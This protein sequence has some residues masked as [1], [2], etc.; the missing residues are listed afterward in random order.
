MSPFLQETMDCLVQSDS[1]QA[2][3]AVRSRPEVKAPHD[4]IVHVSAVALN[5]TDFKSPASN[6]TPGA[7]MGCDFMGSVVSAGTAADNE[8]PPATRVCGFVHGSNPGNPETGSFAEYLVTDSRLLIRVPDSWTNVDGAALGGVGWGTVAL[9]M[10]ISLQL[11]GR[12]S[13]P[14]APRDDGS[15]T[16][17]LVYGGA[18]ATGTMACQILSMSGYQPVATASS[19]SSTLVRD[20]GAVAVVPYSSPTCGETIRDDHTGGALR[21]ALDCI[22]SP[23]SVKCCFTALGRIGARYAGLD[24]VPDDWRTR[25]AI[26]VH[27][28]LTYAL[29]GHEIK[30]KGAYHRDADPAML[31]LGGRWRDEVQG[32][33]DAGRLRPHP[34]RE[35]KGKWKGIVDGL[36]MMKAGEVRGQKL[37]VALEGGASS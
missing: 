22:S 31:E 33:V 4:V 14:A 36:E 1:G 13:K 6:P 32:L 25:K 30:F 17:V 18:T 15:R 27:M 34:A 9:A 16:P 26:K 10:E 12:P 20:Y 5:P 29:H 24:F 37:V 28:P 3:T 7:I 35:V 23:E 21:H 2:Q 11:P 19:S 8:F